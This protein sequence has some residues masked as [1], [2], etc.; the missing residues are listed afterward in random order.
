MEQ[1]LEETTND[2]SAV[3]IIGGILSK[4]KT[5]AKIAG[6]SEIYGFLISPIDKEDGIVYDAILAK[7]Q[8]V[9]AASASIDPTA[10]GVAKAE[11]E[12]LGYKAIG[13]WHSHGGF[14][15][16]H[17]GTDDNNMNRLLRSF[18]S[19]NERRFAKHYK[20][21]RYID[22]DQGRI[23]YRTERFEIA[24]GLDKD[25]LSY[26]S[27]LLGKDYLKL[28]NG[29]EDL[30]AVLTSDSKLLIKDGSSVIIA[31]NPHV[32]EIR[33]PDLQEVRL[34]GVAYSIVVNSAGDS[35]AEMAVN[36]WCSLCEREEIDIKKRVNI[37]LIGSEVG[38]FSEEGLEKD[39]EERV[40]GFKTGGL[41][42][43]MRGITGKG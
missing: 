33:K 43:W 16:W 36:K 28:I 38:D 27:K 21:Y 14:G 34:I 1:T 4:I 8:K 24:V 23:V 10:A 30:V 5:Y 22:A 18:A 39:L 3:P 9:S 13:F 25:D 42:K 20:N 32:I 37:K 35:Y 2:F 19:N 31:R 6:S 7:N 15:A 12:N 41:M 26:E 17:S 11:I 40:V 29:S